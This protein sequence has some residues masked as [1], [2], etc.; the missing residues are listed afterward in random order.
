M[1]VIRD[2]RVFDSGLLPVD[3]FE[4]SKGW[5]VL[6][7]TPWKRILVRV[8][9][10]CFGLELNTNSFFPFFL[11]EIY[12]F[13]LGDYAALFVVIDHKTQIVFLCFV[14]WILATAM[15]FFFSSRAE[16]SFCGPSPTWTIYN[17]ENIHHTMIS[18]FIYSDSALNCM[19]SPT[20]TRCVNGKVIWLNNV[21]QN[22]I[23]N[24][25][26]AARINIT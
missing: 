13:F 8:L 17:G 12:A 5:F 25:V 22:W 11:V 1:N 3:D 24:L 21:S 18:L 23:E 7:L 16:N 19:V 6:E 9:S 4:I 15:T 20:L 14:F 10:F 26:N 2:S